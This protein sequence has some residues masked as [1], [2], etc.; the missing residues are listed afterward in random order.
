MAKSILANIT[1]FDR[2]DHVTNDIVVEAF[3]KQA[4]VDCVLCQRNN[5]KTVSVMIEILPSQIGLAWTQTVIEFS[6]PKAK[7]I[8]AAGFHENHRV[9]NKY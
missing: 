8:P 6:E 2:K 1:A 3:T 7:Y 4:L 9:V 5:R